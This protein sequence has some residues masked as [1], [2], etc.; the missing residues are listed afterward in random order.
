MKPL[1]AQGHN[2]TGGLAALSFHCSYAG[3][4]YPEQRYSLGKT[5]QDAGEGYTTLIFMLTWSKYLT[6]L[7]AFGLSASVK[8]AFGTIRLEPIIGD[9]FNNYNCTVERP[10]L[11]QNAA[12]GESYKKFEFN[13]FGLVEI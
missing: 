2:N 7:T 1:F 13:V 11:S 6:L 12:F 10:E 9:G 8:S 5:V 4:F 3:I